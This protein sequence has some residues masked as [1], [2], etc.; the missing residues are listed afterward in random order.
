MPIPVT[1][2]CRNKLRKNGRFPTFYLALLL[3]SFH[4]ATVVYINSSYLEQF[5]SSQTIGLLYIVGALCTALGFMNASPALN[6][7]G[8]VRL[9]VGLTLIEFCALIGMAFVTSPF[10]AIPLFVIHLAV[11]PCILFT[12]DV[13]MEELIGSHEGSTGSHRGLFLTIASFTAACAAFGVGKLLGSETPDFFLAYLASAAFLIPFLLIIFL[14]F[15]CFINPPYERLDVWRGLKESWARKDVRN[16]F[17]AHFLLQLFFS[18]M[19]IYTP[20]YLSQVIGFN[21]EE[22]GTILFIGLM[23]YVFLEYAIGYLADHFYGEKEMMAFGF[24]VLAISTSWFVFLDEST[25][26]TW[27]IAMFMTRVGASLVETT[28]ESYF[29]K[30]IQGKDTNVMGLFR[31]AQPLGYMVG[32]TLGV[33]AISFFEFE[34]LFVILG[35]LM[36]PGLFFAMALHDSK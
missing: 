4:Y 14:D 9:V 3:L 22:I 36:L 13:F 29:F 16:V 35:L 26:F 34:F 12:L 1:F 10:V 2:T 15:R 6:K 17:F 24:T 19:V 32:A 25:V 11:V 8:N 18:W 33:I 20:V 31:I 30:Q 27:M 21:W 28:T 23:A 5:V 7:F